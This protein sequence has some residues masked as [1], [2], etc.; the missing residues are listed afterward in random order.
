MPHLRLSLLASAQPAACFSWCEAFSSR[1][2]TD[3]LDL[4]WLHTRSVASRDR[5]SKL[6]STWVP[7][8]LWRL[9]W[10]CHVYGHVCWLSY[11]SRPANWSTG[12][13][14][15]LWRS[16]CVSVSTD[17]QTDSRTDELI[18]GGLGNLR[19]LQVKGYFGIHNNQLGGPFGG[20]EIDNQLGTV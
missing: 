13:K 7:P 8:F 3:L 20:N 12:L 4:S 14:F 16:N 1:E 18:W 19:F 5:R 10:S 15:Y 9:D 17:S 2:A 11:L 6:M